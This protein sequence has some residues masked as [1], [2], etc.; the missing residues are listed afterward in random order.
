MIE[1]GRHPIT[2]HYNTLGANWS[3]EQFGRNIS[4]AFENKPKSQHE[5]AW[6]TLK[7][8]IFSNAKATHT[9]I[10]DKDYEE[11]GILSPRGR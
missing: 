8:A 6:E 1:E 11:D 4:T 5:A 2:V 7:K 9:R 3:D 10:N